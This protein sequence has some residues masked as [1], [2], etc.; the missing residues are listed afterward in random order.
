MALS[1]TIDGVDV[2]AQLL[3][4]SL[5]LKL[6]TLDFALL[7]VPAGHAAHITGYTVVL[8]SPGEIPTWTGTVVRDV[9]RP[10]SN[11]VSGQMTLEVS[12]INADAVPAFSPAP[13]DLSDVSTGGMLELEDGSG[14]LLLEDGLGAY[15]TEDAAYGYE[16][17]S[18]SFQHDL[19]GINTTLGELTTYQPG[20]WPGQGFALYCAD[21]Y[22]WLGPV[23][24]IIQR[25]TVT[26]PA[27]PG[28][29]E[30]AIE[31][32]DL[33]VTFRHFLGLP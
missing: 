8:A 14:Q 15:L 23:I 32:G 2:T 28:K 4:G 6:N 1:L 9:S 20:L 3:Y 22:P 30:Y 33:Q 16:G 12:A 17:L 27:G 26:Y 5:V 7:G 18:I 29:P 24:Y 25:V 11:K 31:F 13:F 21:L 10:A 19:D